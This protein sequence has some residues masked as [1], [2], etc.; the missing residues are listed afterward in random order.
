MPGRKP[1][2]K[3][4][5]ACERAVLEAWKTKAILT[6]SQ[7]ITIRNALREGLLEVVQAETRSFYTMLDVSLVNSCGPVLV[8]H[9]S[10]PYSLVKLR[11]QLTWFY[12]RGKEALISLQEDTLAILLNQLAENAG[13]CVAWGSSRFP[14][15]RIESLLASKFPLGKPC[16][17]NS[18]T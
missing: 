2:T 18:E 5:L 15:K 10:A 1:G 13:Q 12:G 3:L 11:F 14:A 16:Q 6:Q 17:C 8:Q 7:V 4:A 9:R